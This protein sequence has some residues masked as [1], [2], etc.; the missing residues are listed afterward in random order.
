MRQFDGKYGMFYRREI[1]R[2][3]LDLDLLPEDIPSALGEYPEIAL[4]FWMEKIL[5]KQFHTQDPDE[6]CEI[7][8]TYQL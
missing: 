8:D 4:L 2:L 5:S 6:I 7:V 3:A 1:Q